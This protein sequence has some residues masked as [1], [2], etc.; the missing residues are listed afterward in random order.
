MNAKKR[1]ILAAIAA[2]L[3]V[4]WLAGGALARGRV[5]QEPPPPP[6][7]QQPIFPPK[8]IRKSGG[9]LQGSATRRVE[10]AYPP[11]AK[12]AQISGA[13]VVEITIDESGNV[14]SA[15]ALSGHPLLKDAAVQAARG[16]TF[17]PTI[18]QGVPVKVIGTVTFNFQLGDSDGAESL[19]A[20]EKQVQEHPESAQAHYDL[21]AALY[22]HGHRPEAVQ[23]LKDAISIDPNFEI[24]YRRLGECL[25]AMGPDR[26]AEAI[27]TLRQAIR[28]NP[29]DVEAE[30]MLGSAY[31]RMQR[32]A[33]AAELY[34]DAIKENPSLGVTYFELGDVYTAIGSYVQAE[35]AYKQGLQK[36]PAHPEGYITLGNLYLKL[37]RP[38]DAIDTLRKA[39][40]LAPR[41]NSGHFALG[42]A[43]ATSGDKKSAM[44][45]YEILKGY[46][47]SMAEKLLKEIN[48]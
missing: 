8:I 34:Q 10:P 44:D 26:E 28:L 30:L 24:A 38:T 22:L 45:E 33:E 3:T 7:P 39:T 37:G 35:D 41:Y 6:S 12:A 42:M 32:Y 16:W 5:L 31:S 18:L 1:T 20:A 14:V 15:N 2:T 27:D 25:M 46:N 17:Q 19:E 11:L 48:K 40:D 4:I 23:S 43:Y 36:M 9:V 13:V 47:P 29:H 21:A